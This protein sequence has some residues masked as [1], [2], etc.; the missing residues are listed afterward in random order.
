[1]VNV[2]RPGAAPTEMEIQVTKKI[3]D[4]VAGLGS[5]DHIQSTITDGSSNTQIEF[6]IGTNTDRA[7]NDVRDAVSKIRQNLPQDILEPSVERINIAGSADPLFQRACA[8][9]EH[10]TTFLADR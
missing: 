4:A 8:L 2:S 9:A 1:M 6:A 7:V 10:R 5:I 3:E